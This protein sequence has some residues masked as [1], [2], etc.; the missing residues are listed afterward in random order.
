MAKPTHADWNLLIRILGHLM[1]ESSLSLT[2]DASS[3]D[4]LVIFCDADYAGD[5]ET[6]CSTT[7]LL[8]TFAG[9][10][11][12]WKSVRQATVARST[13]EAETVSMCHAVDDGLWLKD[14]CNEL[15]L[16]DI[17]TTSV[18]CD[19][20]SAV[21]LAKRERTVQRTKHLKTKYAYHLKQIS[22]EKINIEHVNT[23]SQLAGMLT[24]AIT[25]RDFVIAREKLMKSSN[26]KLLYVSLLATLSLTGMN[27]KNFQTVNLSA[28]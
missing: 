24:K 8:V 21:K 17:Q 4:D 26:V 22:L 12:H 2:Y 19:N 16:S 13:T 6:S 3:R 18:F 14:C 5:D 11:I 1:R 20:E 9:A 7:G 15:T 25:I 28:N 27:A 10:P 23:K